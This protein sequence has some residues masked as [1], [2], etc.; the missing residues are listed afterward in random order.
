MKKILLVSP[1][2]IGFELT[3][4]A[5]YLKLPFTKIKRFIMPLHIATIAGL[6]PDDIEVVLWDEALHG[7]IGDTTDLSSYDLVAITGFIGHL[8][9]ALEIAKVV[10]K[11]GV[12]V[13]V[14]G[15]GVSSQ[16]HR[17]AQDFDH[18]FI[19]EAELIWPKF[20]AD[21]QKGVRQKIYRQVGQVDLALTP[22]PRWGN[23]AKEVEHYRLGAVQT[24]RGCPFDCEFCDV[25]LLFGE[26]YRSKPIDNVLQEVSELEK[27]GA[28]VIVFCDDNFIGNPGYAKDLLKELI[29]LN[30]SFRRPLGFGSEM[31]INLAKDD[32]LLELL[33]DANFREIFIGIESFNK[34]S[35]KETN[36]LQNV[37]AD[38]VEDIKKIQSYALPV[39][40]SIIVGFDHDTK[41]IFEQTFQ[42]AQEACLAVP[43]IR[44]LMAPPGTRLWKR[45]LADGRLLDTQTEGRFFGNP[46]TTNILPKNMTRVELHTGFL[47]LREKIYDWD[48]FAVRAK[49]LIANLK[50]KP[51]VPR[52]K[53]NLKLMIQFTCFFFSKLID[54]H[55]RKVIFDILLYTRKHAPFML[56]SVARGILRQ[57]GYAYVNTHKLKDAVQRQID[58]EKSG[59]LKPE[60][61]RQKP[62]VPDSFHEFYKAV[63][64]EICTEVYESISD[65]TFTDGTLIEIF[66]EFIIDRGKAVNTLTDADKN[67]LL[68]LT[69]QIV[70][71][72]NID[73]E[74]HDIESGT[75]NLPGKKKTILPDEIFK[76][77]QQE[78][79]IAK[80]YQNA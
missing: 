28:S 50:R 23:I 47:K 65:K 49:G 27:I 70:T 67:D 79:M 38:I 20:I 77:M 41:D 24:S 53:G 45:M 7:H 52:Q 22:P 78:L 74:K 75:E 59:E 66:K 17:F 40:G 1:V 4:D 2:P 56:P 26:R 64:P 57:F 29:K 46:G 5:S 55:T 3:Q 19:G 63:F 48:N 21:R 13:A 68:T 58:L 39:R 6:T 31:S 76:A 80:T 43:S 51:N 16:P 32:E 35:L 9:R 11:Q 62:L 12:P 54:N 30:N 42:F 36:K 73:I 33:A 34:E 15:P 14:G 10:R 37:R 61:D 44:T 71:Q 18:L 25:S 60:I 72:K 69:R 8:G